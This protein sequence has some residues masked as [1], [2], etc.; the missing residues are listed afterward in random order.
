MPRANEHG[1]EVLRVTSPSTVRLLKAVLDAVPEDGT[2]EI[3]A[4]R[5]PALIVRAVDPP[6]PL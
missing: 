5:P 3:V 4:T 1:R 6:L 2:V